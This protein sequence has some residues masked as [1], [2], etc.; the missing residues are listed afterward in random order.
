MSHFFAMVNHLQ[1]N[2]SSANDVIGQEMT[3]NLEKN[4]FNYMPQTHVGSKSFFT[5]QNVTV[6][7]IQECKKIEV[8]FCASMLECLPYM[9]TLAIFRCN[10]L[11]QII[12]EDTKNKTK[13]FFP[14]LKYLVIVG[15]NKLKCVFPI[16][17]SK[18][19][20][21][22]EVL[23]IVEACMLE[24]VF[25][26]DTDQRA[27]IPNMKTLVFVELP[28]LCQEIEFFTVKDCCVKNCPK[29]SLSSSLQSFQDIIN[30]VTGTTYDTFTHYLYI[31]LLLINIF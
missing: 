30:S 13:P 21:E 29:L 4:A 20:S 22:L 8:I 18:M 3:V 24:Q 27:E 19:L 11:K 15:C 12:G 5:L 9:H 31:F 23:V 6:L 25:Q 2:D 28:R 26:G 1:V 10:E 16:S 17:T 7:S 14:R